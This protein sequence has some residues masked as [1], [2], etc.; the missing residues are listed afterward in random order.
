[1]P[2]T[3]E[4]CGREIEKGYRILV[5]GAELEVCGRCAELG[6]KMKEIKE[7]STT[8]EY[9]GRLIKIH[10]KKRDIL[11]TGE[12]IRED[13]AEVIRGAREAKGLTQ[14]KLAEIINEKLSLIKKIERGEIIPEDK[15]RKKLERELDVKL[16]T[17]V[18]N[19]EWKKEERGGELTL[20]DIVKIKRK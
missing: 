1:M 15:V 13:Y 2:K 4:I 11:D 7:E 18:S 8:Y 10:P 14:D 20:G 19:V 12:E 17:H 6:T 9:K 5:E 16:I 3:C